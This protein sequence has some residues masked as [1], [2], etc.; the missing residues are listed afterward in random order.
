MQA[1]KLGS[2]ADTVTSSLEQVQARL[3]AMQTPDGIIE[4]KLQPF[5]GG[6]TKAINNQSKATAEQIGN[7][8]SVISQFDE[9]VRQLAEQLTEMARS[10]SDDQKFLRELLSKLEAGT[11]ETQR[12]L[13]DIDKKFATSP[14]RT[15]DRTGLF[16]GWLRGSTS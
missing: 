8:Q 16:P 15:P 2:T 7:L 10:R 1:E 6:F 12:A 4:V 3:K 9:S 5:I 11:A 14:V 13:T